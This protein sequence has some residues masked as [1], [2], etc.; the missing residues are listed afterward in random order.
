M[1]SSDLFPSHDRLLMR[2]RIYIDDYTYVNNN[3]KVCLS[4][5][6]DKNWDTYN[7]EPDWAHT[8]I[9]SDTTS[10]AFITCVN[11]IS[12]GTGPMDRIGRNI[13]NRKLVINDLFI[14][15][16]KENSFPPSTTDY[17]ACNA[18]R[19]S[20]IW[21]KQP[22]GGPI[23]THENI[24]ASPDVLDEEVEVSLFN[25]PLNMRNIS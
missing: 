24:F 6:Y 16:Y 2:K 22:N 19:L 1:C 20:V 4:S 23:P 18:L 15:N 13:R 25:S 21:D 5:R 3:K 14:W 9:G 10:N 11:D 7:D 8:R 17:I 12:I